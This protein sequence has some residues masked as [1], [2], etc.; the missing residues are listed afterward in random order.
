V[1]ADRVIIATQLDPFLS[2]K[3]AANY[4]GSQLKRYAEVSMVRRIR[5]S[6]AIE[7]ARPSR[8]GALKS[9]RGWR[10]VGRL[11][12]QALSQRCALWG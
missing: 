4:T 3:A 7:S 2:L 1:L 11:G 10:C 6:P 12:G 5:P 9:I 8:S